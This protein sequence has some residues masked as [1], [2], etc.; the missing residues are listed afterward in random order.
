[1]VESYKKIL[2]AYEGSNGAKVALKKAVEI[3]KKFDAEFRTIFVSTSK[4]TDD[5]F[6]SLEQIQLVEKESGVKLDFQVR[7]GS[8]S[9]AIVAEQKAYQPD[10][11]V[12]GSHGE[13]GF[14][15]QF[16][17]STAY[18]VANSCDCPVLIIPE[19]AA[20]ID[21]SNIL[22]PVDSSPE[23]RQKFGYA[24]RLA[25]AFGSTAHII[26]VSKNKDSETQKYVNVYVH[27]GEEF[28]ANRG[29]KY[30]SQIN[31]GQSVASTIIDAA[32]ALNCGLIVSMTENE[33]AGFLLGPSAMQ[34]VN[35]SPYPVLC[36]HNH[37]IEGIG[38]GGL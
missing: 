9:S 19:N 26:G 28:M 27:Q 38:G 8:P 36:I 30:S 18:R 5:E 31:I 29:V 34:L 37:H 2:I 1:M 14:I 7:T 15:P 25:L 16:L 13:T 3:G 33:K 17:G 21:F 20:S 22:V 23:T 10:L 11:V 35:T 6:V 24:A 4:N 12:M 32:A